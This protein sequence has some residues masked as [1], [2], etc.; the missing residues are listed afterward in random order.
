[1]AAKVSKSLDRVG[2]R[3]PPVLTIFMY[4]L[5]FFKRR[6]LKLIKSKGL[7]RLGIFATAAPKLMPD[8]DAD[9]MDD[10]SNRWIKPLFDQ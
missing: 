1:M 4:V 3:W 7:G 8:R 9:N 5:I 10:W 2:G 6:N